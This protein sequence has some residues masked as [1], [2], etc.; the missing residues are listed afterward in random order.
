VNISGRDLL[1]ERFAFV[2]SV[3][4][5]LLFRQLVLLCSC[6]AIADGYSRSLCNAIVASVS[7]YNSGSWTRV[8]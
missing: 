4:V 7:T 5:T 6:I 3:N 1:F 8:H 2:L